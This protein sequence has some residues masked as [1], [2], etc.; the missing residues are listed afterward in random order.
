M[1]RGRER[2][3][4]LRGLGCDV[5]AKA[6]GNRGSDEIRLGQSPVLL[7]LKEEDDLTRGPR[8][9][10]NESAGPG[11]LS[12]RERESC[13]TMPWAGHPG[14][15][16]SAQEEGGR[17]RAGLLACWARGRRAGRVGQKPGE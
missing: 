4:Y 8:A 6:I 2:T 17:N 15:A 10:V 7:R 14:L 5:H 13:G 12:Q 1:Q 3:R 11:Y 16:V 9:S